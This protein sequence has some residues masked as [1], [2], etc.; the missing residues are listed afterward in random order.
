MPSCAGEVGLRSFTRAWLRAEAAHQGLSLDE[1]DVD[2]VYEWVKRA[3]TALAALRA[4]ETEG[5]W[6]E[7]LD[8]PCQIPKRQF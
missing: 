5:D 8:S 2:A 7:G 6:E 1:A 3:K 4:N